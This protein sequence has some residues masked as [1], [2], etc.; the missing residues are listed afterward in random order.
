MFVAES[1]VQVYI[2]HLMFEAKTV[3]PLLQPIQIHGFVES[4]GNHHSEMMQWQMLPNLQ[5]H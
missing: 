5:L 3:L 1:Q 4:A 2:L